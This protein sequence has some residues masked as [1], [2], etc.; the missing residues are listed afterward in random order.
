MTIF[1]VSSMNI[2]IIYHVFEPPLLAENIHE[3][4]IQYYYFF[5]ER[6]VPI[7]GEDT[8]TLLLN[9]G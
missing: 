5:H 9:Y 3:L 6:A 1:S 2:G 8:T 4:Q 7:I